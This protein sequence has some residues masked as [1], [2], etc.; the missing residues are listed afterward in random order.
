M[1]LTPLSLLIAE[2]DPAL[3]RMLGTLLRAE[4]HQVVFAANGNEALK[5]LERGSVD[6]IITDVM[7]P[8]KDG[9]EFIEEVRLKRPLLP[10]VAVSGGGRF[11]ADKPYY[12]NVAKHFGATICLPKPFSRQELLSAIDE[13]WTKSSPPPAETSAEELPRDA[14]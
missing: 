9:L 4:G 14:G 13:A 3:R 1:A 2:D 11:V 5:A 12:L 7:M 10:I 6:L 8:E